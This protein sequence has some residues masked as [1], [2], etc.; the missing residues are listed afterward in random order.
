M[1]FAQTS[2]Q[3]KLHLDRFSHLCTD[4][5]EVSL[6]FTMVCLFSL[7]IAPSHVGIWASFNT[8]FIGL[9]QV[10]NANGNLIAS[11]VFAGLTD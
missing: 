2:P 9:T 3:P 8:W 1:L 10:R 6:Y 5:R 4:D 11:A 7:K